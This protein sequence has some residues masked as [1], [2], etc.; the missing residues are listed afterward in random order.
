MADDDWKSSYAFDYLQAA[1]IMGEALDELNVSSAHSSEGD[2]DY[3]DIEGG[4]FTMKLYHK[5]FRMR[6][7]FGFHGW[8]KPTD[9]SDIIISPLEDAN[10]PKIRM[11]LQ[12]FVEKSPRR[13]WEFGTKVKAYSIGISGRTKKSWEN[14]I[15]PQ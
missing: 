6:T 13:P 3:F 15:G 7:G 12:K 2:A 10:E 1:Q 9:I 14:W 5:R 4:S 11:I 8:L